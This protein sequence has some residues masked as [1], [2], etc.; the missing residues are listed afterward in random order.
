MT[1]P[2][3][4]SRAPHPPTCTHTHIHIH[5][6]ST[7]HTHVRAYTYVSTLIHPPHLHSFHHCR[8]SATDTKREKK[9]SVSSKGNTGKTTPLVDEVIVTPPA[10]AK[11]GKGRK[12]SKSSKASP[13][14]RESVS[15][16]GPAKT[17]TSRP[18]SA[19][20]AHRRD[21][22]AGSAER[23]ASSSDLWASSSTTPKP[24]SRGPP[25]RCECGRYFS[26]H[27]LVEQCR[28]SHQEMGKGKGKG[29]G[30]KAIKSEGAS[31]P[32][33]VSPSKFKIKKEPR[34]QIKK[35]PG[36]SRSG[37][38]AGPLLGA[39]LGD[40]AG[41]TSNVPEVVSVDSHSQMGFM[42][43]EVGDSL[44]HLFK[45]CSTQPRLPR[46]FN[47]HTLYFHTSVYLGLVC[48]S[49]YSPA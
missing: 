43:S 8:Q 24:A 49:S 18:P 27:D 47:P 30:R 4:P 29:K 32:K 16:S 14:D 39:N 44:K 31:P 20:S 45:H 6:H 15:G 33:S 41:L 26:S 28:K 19:S 48:S 12:S 2:P 1:P 17:P 9:G 46:H 42:E 23:P 13:S 21:S 11:K 36:H 5:T 3:P 34:V 25:P 37:S 22:G 10:Q 7:P 38:R 35:E 40:T